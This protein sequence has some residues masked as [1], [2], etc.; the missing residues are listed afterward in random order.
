MK[1]TSISERKNFS[2]QE[3][4]NFPNAAIPKSNLYGIT[5]LLIR[6]SIL[7]IAVCLF[8]ISIQA[9]VF[10]KVSID[11]DGLFGKNTMMVKYSPG[12]DLGFYNW[13]A[14]GEDDGGSNYIG[15]DYNLTYFFL[16]N[17]GA[18]LKVAYS[19]DAFNDTDE[20]RDVYSD[21]TVGLAGVYGTNINDQLNAYGKLGFEVGTSKTLYEEE[22]SE[23]E[24]K[25]NVFGWRLEA[26]LPIDILE[27]GRVF[28]T[29][30]IGYRS[31]GYSFDGG[32][33]KDGS[34]YIGGQLNVALGCLDYA[35]D[36]R[37]DW[38][39]SEDRYEQGTSLIGG[40]F[41]TRLN[42]GSWTTTYDDTGIG[43]SEFKST[44]NRFKFN[45]EAF[46]YFWDNIAPGANLYFNTSTSKPENSENK[47]TSS[48]WRFVPMVM[49]NVPVDGP[50]NNAFAIVGFGIGQN[51]SKSV[52]NDNET[53]S[54]DFV[55]DLCA[56]V[57]FNVFVTKNLAIT[58][59]LLYEFNSNNDKESDF[60]TTQS[61]LNFT[62]GLSH[63][64]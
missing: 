4:L 43:E 11:D 35:C 40:S 28:L 58:N 24:N 51:S 30:V 41:Y 1:K 61:G 33:Q 16:Q 60:K 56:G 6:K 13:K 14:D 55:L 3:L 45:A 12:L 50:L 54:S 2:K 48:S 21:F 27:E 29:P 19:R 44:R 17:V 32:K 39:F 22:G 25:D 9:Q 34:F 37:N 42:T 38:E 53:V 57:G 64:F 15:F 31:R 20:D 52:F 10:D 36:M 7:L 8:T 23:S 5:S 46:H 59:K 62:V 47:N 49:A 26:G 18:E 63:Y